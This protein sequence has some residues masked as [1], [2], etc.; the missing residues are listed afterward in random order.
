VLAD[1]GVDLVQAGQALR[2]HSAEAVVDDHHVPKLDRR[3]RPRQDAIGAAVDPATPHGH[4]RGAA[5]H[6]PG[7]AVTDQLDAVEVQRRVVHH[8]QAAVATGPD[9]R[10]L[11]VDLGRAHLEAPPAWAQP[12][13]GQLRAAAGAADNTVDGT[14]QRWHGQPRVA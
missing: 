8:D 2:L 12:T 7:P 1:L 9:A 5:R 13:A 10:A 6:Q 14:W 11:H 4:G 3:C